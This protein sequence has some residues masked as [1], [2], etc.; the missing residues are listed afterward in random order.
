ME[1]QGSGVLLSTIG[2]GKTAYVPSL[3]MDVMV[4]SV[5]YLNVD[6]PSGHVA[7]LELGAD[8]TCRGTV[9]IIKD[10]RAVR[11]NF[12]ASLIGE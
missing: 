7:V 9:R 12:K 6:V 4:V 10:E 2:Y 1:V 5:S 8:G 11:V 3:S